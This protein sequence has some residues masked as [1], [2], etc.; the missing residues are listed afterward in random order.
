[1]I[2]HHARQIQ[3]LIIVYGSNGEPSREE[4]ELNKKKREE[5]E[6]RKRGSNTRLSINELYSDL[7]ASSKNKLACQKRGLNNVG[8]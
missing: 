4:S 3:Q 1:M 5:R 8:G 7:C 2:G 6:E